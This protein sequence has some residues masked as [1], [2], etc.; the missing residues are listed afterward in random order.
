LNSPTISTIATTFAA[1][2]AV[3]VATANLSSG[4]GREY[5][6]IG[7]RNTIFRAAKVAIECRG[8]NPHPHPHRTRTR[9]SSSSQLLLAKFKEGTATID[10]G[11]K[12]A[13]FQHTSNQSEIEELFY[14][15]FSYGK[16]FTTTGHTS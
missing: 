16:G 15:T 4:C 11:G 6:P 12:Q 2:A 8:L 7:A 5:S 10:G 3:V 13:S 9:C 14:V 1:A